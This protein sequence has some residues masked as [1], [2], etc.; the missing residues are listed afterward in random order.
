MSGFRFAPA[1][2]EFSLINALGCA[3]LAALA[4]Q[5]E[6]ACARQT[7]AWG[8]DRFQAL[9]RGS[10]F[11]F[12]C[13]NRDALFVVFRG[14]DEGA[15]WK[16]NVNVLPGSLPWGTVHG[17]F[18]A[19]AE[20]FWPELPAVIGGFGD[21]SQHV[22]ITGHSLGGALAL[23]AAVRLFTE[24][25][26]PLGG[27]YTFGQPPV[28]NASFRLHFKE[29]FLRR[30]FRFVNH[31]DKVVNASGLS[32]GH[33]GEEKYFD[34]NGRLWNGRPFLR[35]L[36]DS[37]LA[38]WRHGGRRDEAEAAGEKVALLAG[39]EAHSMAHYCARIEAALVRGEAGR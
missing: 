39:I 8:L 27:L 16:T 29:Q 28:G 36:L 25:A 31:V 17:G 12:V 2:F 32:A 23:L 11:G 33:V 7:V 15:D 1:D 13:G 10:N 6:A 5:D 21:A 35:G 38:E 20:L 18:L 24:H 34:V 22:W 19:A 3:R 4:Y 14:T 26:A 30:Y 9:I 37:M